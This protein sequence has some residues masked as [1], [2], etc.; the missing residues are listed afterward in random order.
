LKN[1]WLLSLS[2][3]A[4][5]SVIKSEDDGKTWTLIESPAYPTGLYVT[6]KEEIIVNNDYGADNIY[7]ST[8][9]GKT[10]KLMHTVSTTFGTSGL[11]Q[12]YFHKYGSYYYELIP[13]H[14]VLKTQNFEQFETIL[15]EPNVG[16]LYIDH[17]GTLIVRGWHEKLN[18]TFF[19]A[20]K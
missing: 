2:E 12:T 10:F 18:R 14:G 3:T 6:E 13:G 8:D 19:Y 1:G 20:R 16:G 15:N 11:Y 17:T 9:L 5:R 4:P 7:K